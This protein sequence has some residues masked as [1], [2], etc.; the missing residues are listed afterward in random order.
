M[1]KRKIRTYN[2][3]TECVVTIKDGENIFTGRARC[4]PEDK[5]FF[6]T[7]TGYIIAELRA[8]IAQI[9]H[10]KNTVVKPKLKT[11]EDLKKSFDCARA[12]D[13]DSYESKLVDRLIK[14][15]KVEL[16]WCQGEILSLKE[17]I[18]AFIAAKELFYTE[19]RSKRNKDPK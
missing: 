17:D 2:D 12:H 11:L 5:D 13:K 10:Y 16:E 4:H 15:Q 19:V 3:G 18:K 7:H 1:G 8:T 14:N 6:S 9:Q